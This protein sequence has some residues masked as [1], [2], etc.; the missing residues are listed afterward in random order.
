MYVPLTFLHGC[1]EE[2]KGIVKEFF[3]SCMKSSI[4][5][6]SAALFYNG[7]PVVIEA[8]W[9]GFLECYNACRFEDADGIYVIKHQDQGNK[10][11]TVPL[12]RYR[13]LYFCV[14]MSVWA[15][16]SK[17]KY[18]FKA[19]TNKVFFDYELRPKKKKK[20]KENADMKKK[21]MAW[22]QPCA[23]WFS[24]LPSHIESKALLRCSYE[25]VFPY[26]IFRV[27][28]V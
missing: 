8:L 12:I 24:G 28:C 2:N 26:D 19:L 1:L 20:K 10:D 14:C 3:Y 13:T 27:L 18:T 25:K 22:N 6:Q 17:D 9:W 7:K 21:S 15:F 23:Q 4:I 5:L 16:V 11:A